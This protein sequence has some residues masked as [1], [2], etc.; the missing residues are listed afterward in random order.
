MR[1]L[2][3]ALQSLEVLL[4]ALSAFQ[5]LKEAAAVLRGCPQ[6]TQL[7]A[8]NAFQRAEV[9]ALQLSSLVPSLE[10][11]PYDP[12]VGSE[13]YGTCSGTA[14]AMPVMQVRRGNCLVPA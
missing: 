4:L 10:W 2:C 12:G 11:P 13:G 3:C 14:G 6:L 1:C 5:R 7:A 9:Y 8:N